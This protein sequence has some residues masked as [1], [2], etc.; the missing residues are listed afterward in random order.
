[1][2]QFDYGLLLLLVCSAVLGLWRGLVSELLALVTW[3]VA[4]WV[5]K[6]YSKSAAEY[7][8]PWLGENLVQGLAGF[9]AVFIGV[10]V[11]MALLRTLL[12]HLLD[13]SGLGVI[14]RIL[15]GVFGIARGLLVAVLMVLLA[16]LTSLPQAPWWQQAKFAA[17][18]ETV[19]LAAKPWLPTLLAER[20]HY[21]KVK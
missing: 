11:V 19:V 7:L 8:V 6:S 10:L 18:L 20:I 21:L 5:A 1:M 17:P 14:D 15:G 3:A 9:L 13:A 16:G 12:R 4:F 2:T